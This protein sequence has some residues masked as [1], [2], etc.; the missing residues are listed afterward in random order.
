MIGLVK[1]LKVVQ[2]MIIARYSITIKQSV[3]HSRIRFLLVEKGVWDYALI[4]HSQRP[5][6]S[7]LFTRINGKGI[8]VNN[9]G[10][11]DSF[12][13]VEFFYLVFV[14]FSRLNTPLENFIV[15]S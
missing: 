8:I 7:L 15:I 13:N 11:L 2:L 4:V 6:L 14:E 10:R 5:Q 12:R 9:P 1:G 3:V